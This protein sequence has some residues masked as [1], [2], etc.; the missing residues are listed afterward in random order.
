[1][2]NIIIIKNNIKK[3]LITKLIQTFIKYIEKYLFTINKIEYLFHNL[4]I[5]Y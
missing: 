4:L 5:Q 3:T 2:Y 1:M